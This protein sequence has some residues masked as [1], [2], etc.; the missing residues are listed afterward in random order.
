MVPFTDKKLPG[1]GFCLWRR[2][3]DFMKLYLE[4][5]YRYEQ[6]TIIHHVRPLMKCHFIDRPGWHLCYPFEAARRS[7]TPFTKEVCDQFFPLYVHCGWADLEGQLKTLK[8]W[9]G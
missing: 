4:K 5:Y 9:Y 6:E 3:S 7:G 2:S 1:T 8:E